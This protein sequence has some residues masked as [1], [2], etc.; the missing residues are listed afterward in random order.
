MVDWV[1]ARDGRLASLV[2]FHDG[3]PMMCPC[4]SQSGGR[5]QNTVRMGLLLWQKPMPIS[6]KRDEARFRRQGVQQGW[7]VAHDKQTHGRRRPYGHRVA[8]L[9][10]KRATRRAIVGH[11]PGACGSVSSLCSELPFVIEFLHASLQSRKK[12]CSVVK[13][14]LPSRTRPDDQIQDASSARS[15]NEGERPQRR[16]S[17]R[18]RLSSYQHTCATTH[19]G[20]GG[21]GGRPPLTPA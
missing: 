13:P 15:K 8:S 7:S 4:R 3:Q 5:E 19:W 9:Q 21:G 12:R 16:K 1:V 10:N 2:R 20:G 14:S 11:S 6:S 18:S 17:P